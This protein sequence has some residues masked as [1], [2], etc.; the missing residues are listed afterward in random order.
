MGRKIGSRGIRL[1][2]V[3]RT[4]WRT[5]ILYG[6]RYR[7]FLDSTISVGSL[8]KYS[9]ITLAFIIILTSV[10]LLGRVSVDDD[11]TG[12]STQL[13]GQT[14]QILKTDIE[15]KEPETKINT[16][17][18]V[19]QDVIEDEVEDVEPEIE[20]VEKKVENVTEPETEKPGS[21]NVSLD[22]P[23]CKPEEPG[24][25]YKYT[26]INVTVSDF[27]KELKGDNWATLAYVTLTLTNNEDCLIVNPTRVK[28]KLNPRGKGSVW[29]D[30]DI[31]LSD[32]FKRMT[33]G[34]TVSEEIPVHVSFS[35]I[36]SEK[37]FKLVVL[38]DYD[39][40]MATFRQYMHM[41]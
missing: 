14:K 9:G 4:G 28:V 13:S 8:L 17:K 34:K 32:A 31:F 27:K 10:F 15:E 6:Y 35:D 25:D 19:A 39:I 29:W 37:E 16:T 18:P 12:Q 41:Y 24:F 7:A 36:Y 26:D 22:I 38:D 33:P 5:S 23:V 2:S 11:I 21:Q 1:R 30:D 3:S 40:T 20:S